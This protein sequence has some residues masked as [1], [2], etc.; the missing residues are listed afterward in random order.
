MDPAGHHRQSLRCASSL[1]MCG[2]L[3]CGRQSPPILMTAVAQTRKDRRVLSI[4]IVHY[5]HRPM[6]LLVYSFAASAPGCRAPPAVLNPAG[7]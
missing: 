5:T 3:P 4:Y 1:S 7:F 6:A 2:D